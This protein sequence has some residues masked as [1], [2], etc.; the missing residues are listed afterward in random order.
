M[1]FV[2]AIVRRPGPWSKVT[3][4]GPGDRR[5][6][7]RQ[8]VAQLWPVGSLRWQMCVEDTENVTLSAFVLAT[9]SSVDAVKGSLEFFR[10][11]YGL[12]IKFKPDHEEAFNKEEYEL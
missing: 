2:D 7:T 4:G 3:T 10:H 12:I 8:E 6:R 5:V 11:R 9:N 1:P